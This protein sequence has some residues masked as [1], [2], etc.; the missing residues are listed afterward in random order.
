MSVLHPS[1][2]AWVQGWA[3]GLCPQIQA[4][5]NR[6]EGFTEYL[7]HRRQVSPPH[8]AWDPLPRIVLRGQHGHPAA[9]CGGLLDW[10]DG[11]NRWVPPCALE[12]QAP[13]W[14][15]VSDNVPWTRAGPV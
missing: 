7:G 14:G 11:G 10:T 13:G 2:G 12:R 3:M 6:W 1:G 5:C 9:A 15:G 4:E 8:P